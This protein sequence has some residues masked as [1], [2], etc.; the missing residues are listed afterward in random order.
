MYL[1]HRPG[2]ETDKNLASGGAEDQGPG[3]G[4]RREPPLDIFVVGEESGLCI[5]QHR[6][7]AVTDTPA[8]Q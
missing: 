7:T 2:W 4:L 8:S 5:R 3:G 6:L 1:G